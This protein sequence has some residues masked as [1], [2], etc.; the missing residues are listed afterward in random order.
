MREGTDR[1]Y[2]VYDHVDPIAVA[3]GEHFLPD[4]SGQDEFLNDVV[5]ALSAQERDVFISNTTT[6]VG[7][8]AYMRVP[9]IRERQSG[10]K[11]KLRELAFAFLDP[12]YG[13]PNDIRRLGGVLYQ[14]GDSF[15]GVTDAQVRKALG[16]AD[17]RHPYFH[18]PTMP[19]GTPL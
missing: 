14:L 1:L 3:I 12:F 9:T 7:P 10:V 2:G 13:A 6:A 8:E 18:R 5:R 19:L 15:S 17:M 11:G 16:N 4:Y